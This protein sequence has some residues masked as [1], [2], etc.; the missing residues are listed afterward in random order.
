MTD[1]EM[2]KLCADAT[3][4][5]NCT[6]HK[7]W[8]WPTYFD[9]SEGEYGE[10]VRY[11]PLNNDSQAMWLV[12]QFRLDITY[13]LP[14][15]HDQQGAWRVRGTVA[16]WDTTENQNLNRAIVECVAKIQS[17]GASKGSG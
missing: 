13:L 9:G 3:N 11:E 7:D 10:H 17:S 12:K 8:A 5:Q 6:C 15:D 14:W 4:T 1:L 2:T 16:G